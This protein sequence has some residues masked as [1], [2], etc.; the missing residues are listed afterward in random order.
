MTE[1]AQRFPPPLGRVKR[2][3]GVRTPV[4]EAPVMECGNSVHLRGIG[5][6][7]CIRKVGHPVAINFG[8]SNGY[9]EWCFEEADTPETTAL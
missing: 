2:I 4:I 8:H 5:L 7:V 3:N 9:E 1:H 6:V